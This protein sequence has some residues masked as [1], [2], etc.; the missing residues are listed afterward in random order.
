MTIKYSDNFYK[1]IG[2]LKIFVTNPRHPGLRLHK[3]GAKEDA[4]SISVDLKLRILFVYRSYGILLVD[5]GT[6]DEVY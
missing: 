2:K 6:H 4:W 3:I 5:I 1:K